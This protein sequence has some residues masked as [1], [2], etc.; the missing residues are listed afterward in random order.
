ME[1]FDPTGLLEL[2]Q[3][4]QDFVLRRAGCLGC[5]SLVCPLPEGASLGPKL[6]DTSLSSLNEK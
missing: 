4:V 2:R 6:L 1:P 3:A 5:S